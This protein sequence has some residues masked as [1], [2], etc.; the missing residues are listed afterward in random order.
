MTTV[1]ICKEQSCAEKIRGD[2]FL[3]REH[4]QKSQVGTIN[5]CPKCGVYKE[6]KY[7]LCIECNK[8]ANAKV[9]ATG[10]ESPKPA[11]DRQ[12]IRPY[13]SA[14]ADTFSERTA[15]LE[16]DQKAKDKRQLFHDQQRKCVYCGNAYRYDELEIE[17]II[18]KKLGGPD[19]IRNCQLACRPCNQ[20]KGTMTDIEFRQKHARYLPQ[21]ERTPA[22]PPIDPKL[23]VSSVQKRPF[24]QSRRR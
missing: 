16:D 2:H 22:N 19:N 7:P 18:P 14:K 21:E 11:E 13:D 8:K 4:W 20:A 5:E 10:K 15:L 1:N 24:W 12:K 17:H 23:L 9:R 3:C 6:S